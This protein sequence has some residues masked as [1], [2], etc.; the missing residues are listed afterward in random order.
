[1][2]NKV[3]GRKW[4]ANYVNRS[5]HK[6]HACTLSA[7][8]RSCH[9]TTCRVHILH[10]VG[11]A[12]GLLLSRQLASCWIY[13]IVKPTLDMRRWW[14]KP[15]AGPGSS[16]P[17]ARPRGTACICGS[18][19]RCRCPSRCRPLDDNPCRRPTRRDWRPWR[20]CGWHGSDFKC[21]EVLSNSRLAAATSN[22]ENSR[23]KV[24]GYESSQGHFTLGNES[25]REPNCQGP[26]IGP[27]ALRSELAR[28]RKVNR[29][30]FV[31]LVN[32]DA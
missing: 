4:P 16:C 17:S 15:C 30:L 26:I 7:S 18:S 31:L 10:S 27:F 6:A 21:S 2:L 20:R 12:A 25:S 9:S 22:S 28:E 8:L 13:S 19:P 24:P 14:S 32:F 1:M 11:V 3:R 23:M 29:S 5:S